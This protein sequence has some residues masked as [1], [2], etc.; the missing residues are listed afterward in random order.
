[1]WSNLGS[2]EPPKK[3][4]SPQH[5]H[6]LDKNTQ[7]CPSDLRDCSNWTYLGIGGGQPGEGEHI[8]LLDG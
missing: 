3:V 6:Y 8:S 4:A 1:M 2:L 7:Y 5:C